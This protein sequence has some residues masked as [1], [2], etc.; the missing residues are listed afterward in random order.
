MGSAIGHPLVGTLCLWLTFVERPPGCVYICTYP[1]LFVVFWW[2]LFP[3]GPRYTL[4]SFTEA[5]DNLSITSCL[6]VCFCFCCLQ[7]NHEL[8]FARWAPHPLF[9]AHQII[10]PCQAHQCS[11]GPPVYSIQQ[12]TSRHLASFQSALPIKPLLLPSV[13]LNPP[14]AVLAHGG[15]R[16]PL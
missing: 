3:H 1:F 2:T 8:F 15:Q 16:T 14:R 7:A 12:E 9:D 11:S 13:N 5:V 4:Q 10:S 6:S